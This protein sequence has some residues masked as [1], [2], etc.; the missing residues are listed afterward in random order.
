MAIGLPPAEVTASM[1]AR[2]GYATAISHITTPAEE[3]ICGRPTGAPFICYWPAGS[4]FKDGRWYRVHRNTRLEV[5]FPGRHEP[6]VLDLNFLVDEIC[7][8]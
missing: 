1:R 4:A 2:L 5:A 6:F 3:V 8:D 7:K